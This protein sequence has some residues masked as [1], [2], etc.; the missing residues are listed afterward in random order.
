MPRKARVDAAG[1]FHHIMARGIDRC[2]IFRND[3]DL[4]DFLRRLSLILPATHTRCFAWALMPNHVH[5]VLKTGDVPIAEVMRRL[6]TGYAVS[7]NRRYRRNGHLFQNRYKS[8]LCDEEPYLLQLVRYVH[9]NPVRANLAEGMA[10]L[11]KYHYCG[12]SALLGK[13]TRDWQDTETVLRRFSHKRSVA[14]QRYHRF[15][16][17]GLT[18]GK[19]DDLIGGGLVRSAGGW[20][21]VQAMRRTDA[22]YA[23]DERM[24]GDG[25]FVE[26]V[27]RE[28]Q[29]RM[30]H[31]LMLHALG[32]TLETITRRVA[33]V[34]GCPEEEVQ[35]PG[36]NPPRVRARSLLCYWAVRELGMSQSDLGRRLNLSSAGVSLS[37]RRGEEL[38]Q[39]LGCKLLER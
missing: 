37:V 8:I 23:S 27:L 14:R 10:G 36:K 26:R 7:F 11:D 30:E 19:R 34:T 35:R 20:S 6:L 22:V 25:P 38:A 17:K 39:Q 2:R 33:E 15:I 29:E 1:T 3:R 28:V 13:H 32:V 12:H 18:Q 21:A 31:G 5:L 16:Q 4:E 9:L 24:L